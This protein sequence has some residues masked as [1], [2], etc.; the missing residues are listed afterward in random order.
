[1][2]RALDAVSSILS[3]ALPLPQEAALLYANGRVQ[4]AAQRL[5]SA[6]APGGGH[7]RDPE[8]WSM[9]LD[10]HRA[11]ADWP[12]FERA[13]TRFE[14]AFGRAA[15]AWL[16][17]E[18]VAHLP[19]E[20]QAGGDA[21][22]EVVGPLD[23]RAAARLM[24]MR[25]RATHHSA[26]HLDLSKAADIDAQGCRSLS[27]TLRFVSANGN[28]V[29]VTGAD[30]IEYLLR[31]AVEG[32]GTARPYWSLLLDLYQLRGMQADFERTAL[33]YA[34]AT[35]EDPPPWQPTVRPVIVPPVVVE[36]R[37]EPRYAAAPEVVHLRGVMS[38]AADSQL[39]ELDRFAVGR[40]YVNINL[41]RVA[42]MDLACATGLA[43]RV[44]EMARAGKTVRLLRP[45]GLIGALLA[46]FD[47]APGVA[48][49]KR[50]AS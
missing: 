5:E 3:Q 8:A 7:E 44:N 2:E 4:Q 38:G 30:R 19:A 24:T 25:N 32:D 15:P 22:F 1:M 34:L 39:R 23:A 18:E 41:A 36:K 46:S 28:G 33:E 20:M 14:A 16:A 49:V 43:A 42:R 11:E 31:T 26:L 37:E 47:L 13:A 10:L 6:I 9:L 40:Q 35:G 50:T 29:L 12:A 48:V 17:V 45:S 21:Y 27:E